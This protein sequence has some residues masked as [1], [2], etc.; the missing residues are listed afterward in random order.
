M[1]YRK[2]P[3]GIYLKESEQ[4]ATNIERIYYETKEKM[5]HVDF[6]R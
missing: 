5:D 4:V 6:N 2:K 1:V 3:P